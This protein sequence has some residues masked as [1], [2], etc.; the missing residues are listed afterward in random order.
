MK[1]HQALYPL[2]ACALAACGGGGDV[3]P[4]GGGTGVPPAA[5][6]Q[7]PIT[8]LTPLTV[9]G[10]PFT[11][12]QAVKPVVED[13]DDDGRG[14]ITGMVVRITGASGPGD[15]E[16]SVISARAAAQVR[17]GVTRNDTA[18]EVM[19]VRII[20]N[21]ETVF[22]DQLLIT[23]G[24]QIGDS[25]QVH[26]YPT[27]DGRVLATR[28]M[29]R[30]SNSVYKTTGVLVPSP[31]LCPPD[32]TLFMLGSL[33]VFVPA[34]IAA[35]LPSPLPSGTPVRITAGSEPV[36][37]AITA[38]RIALHADTT[39]P[40]DALTSVRG[41]VTG[42]TAVNPGSNTAELR[43][44]VDGVPASTD[45]STV[46][47]GGTAGELIDGRVVEVQGVYRSNALT[48]KQ[49]RYLTF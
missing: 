37:G 13:N 40:A 12:A 33:K 3:A 1:R 42:T 34:S 31:C 17:G 41:A 28:I 44:M 48:G 45:A 25:L 19:G 23:V 2:I 32:R 11:G 47:A 36:N 24:P 49:V 8:S 29:R 6:T 39:I 22:E 38:T 7:G 4:G 46:F 43:F 27:A 18:L 9:N 35:A 10:I 5:F 20:A 16:R 14:L 21:N 30:T 26:G 15:T